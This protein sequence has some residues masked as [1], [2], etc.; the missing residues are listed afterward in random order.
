VPTISLYRNDSTTFFGAIPELAGQRI[1]W[2]K[3]YITLTNVASISNY[4][5]KSFVYS[6]YY[7][8]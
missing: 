4:A 6:V 1:V 7:S 8:Y 2:A 3:S 5:N